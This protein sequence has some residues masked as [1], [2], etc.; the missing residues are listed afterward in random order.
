[1]KYISTIPICS[2]ALFRYK[3]DIPNDLTLKFKKEKF[4]S[5]MAGSAFMGGGLNILKKY[6]NLNKEIRKA[7]DATLKKI[8]ILKNINYRIFSS[9]LTKTKP[10]G[11]SDSHAH[12]N[13]WLS[14][15]Y[16]PKSDPGFSIKFF[17]DN[18]RPFSTPPTKYNVYNST[19]WTIVPQDNFLILCFSQLRHQL[20]PNRST[21]DRFSLA[22]N[23]LPRGKFGTSDSKTIF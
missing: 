1:M 3:L 8:L 20:M 10:E 13:S 14:G 15:V 22:F 7:V 12:S 5:I 6:E 18:R 21:K 17:Y 23:I 11:F 16:Y 9:W 4:K 2:N 19:D